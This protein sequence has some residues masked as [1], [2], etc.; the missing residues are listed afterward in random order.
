MNQG[1]HQLL[2]LSEISLDKD[3]PRIAKWLDTY[4]GEI[5]PEQIQMALGSPGDDNESQGGTKYDTLKNSIL[6]NGGIIQPILVHQLPNGVKVCIEGN[7]R[8]CLYQW[9]LKNNAEGNWDSI[10]AIVYENL[11]DEDIEAIRL[12]AHLVGPRQWDPYSKAKYLSYLRNKEKMGM[13]RLVDFC[14][15]SKKAV[16]ECIDAYSEME[17][18]YRPICEA[19]G[20]ELEPRKFSGFVEV[21]RSSV[22]SSII[23]AGFNMSDFSQWMYDN[24]FDRLEHVRQLPVILADLKARAIFLTKGSKE[25][26]KVLERPELDKALREASIAQLAQALSQALSSIPYSDVLEL[27]NDPTSKTLR[28]LQEVQDSVDTFLTSI[29]RFNVD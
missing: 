27:K 1:N 20:A 10:Q 19:D 15:G 6:T 22:K 23:L 21:Q 28:E 11:D 14:G 29:E 17:T 16:N 9:F 4:E 12:Q 13:N 8:V 5:S 18:H 2:K 26:L 24:K 3:N 7:T 25:A